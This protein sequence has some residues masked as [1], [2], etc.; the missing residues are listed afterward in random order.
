MSTEET[1]AAPV[2]PTPAEAPAPEAVAAPAEAATPQP[3]ATPAAEAT[4]G[5]E[6]PAR[7]VADVVFDPDTT[8]DFIQALEH[9]L[10]KDGKDS[11]KVDPEV[12]KALPLDAQKILTNLRRMALKQ[13]DGFAR[14]QQ[15]VTSSREALTSERAQFE[16][17]KAAF[18]AMWQKPELR[19]LVD[20]A[21]AL[22]EPDYF[23]DPKAHSAWVSKR[24][25]AESFGVFLNTIQQFSKEAQ[26]AANEVIATQQEA[27][28]LADLKTFVSE[29]DDFMEHYDEMKVLVDASNGSIDAKRAYVIVRAEKGL[30]NQPKPDPVG[31]ARRAM[32]AKG[33]QIGEVP[34]MPEDL[35]PMQR[36]QWLEANPLAKKATF[37]KFEQQGAS[38]Y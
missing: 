4:A 24:E 13:S 29:H 35:S 30:L 9:Q 15:E 38:V 21:R 36:W 33:G 23:K 6:T 16:S 18:H 8:P 26:D 27:R 22:E 5:D 2:E 19:A 14:G 12:L 1:P 7:S 31:D 17:E 37:D 34:V 25:A 11:F 32:R 3:E 20:E 10:T 28:D